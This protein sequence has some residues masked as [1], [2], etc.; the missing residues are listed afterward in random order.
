MTRQSWSQTSII[1]AAQQR[2]ANC[3]SLPRFTL[4]ASSL[5]SASV[6]RSQWSTPFRARVR[7]AKREAAVVKGCQRRG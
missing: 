1:R 3:P 7:A 6:T 4:M 2:S 5:R